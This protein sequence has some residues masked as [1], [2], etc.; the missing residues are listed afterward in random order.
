MARADDGAVLYWA[1]RERLPIMGTDIFDDK[2]LILNSNDQRRNVVDIDCF[3]V[4]GL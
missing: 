3:A 4:S 1:I 2:V